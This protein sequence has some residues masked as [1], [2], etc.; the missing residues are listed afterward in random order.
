M[1]LREIRPDGPA[2]RIAISQA[3]ACLLSGDDLELAVEVGP[4]ASL[5][6]LEL[7]GMVAHAT[8]KGSKSR[9]AFRA[10]LARN[11][12][13]RW[14]SQPFVFA[15]DCDVER[16]TDLNLDGGAVALLDETLVFGRHGEQ[17]GCFT[18]HTRA[19]VDGRPLLDERMESGF[20]LRS[21]AGIGTANRVY[22]SLAL[23]GMSDPEPSPGSM[24]LAG[25]GSVAR[26]LAVEGAECRGRS[27]KLRDRWMRLVFK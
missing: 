5:D 16:R 26:F 1:R 3:E 7:G 20:T 23:L 10:D 18:S 17:P 13:L 8:R 6:L 24:E 22:G 19:M 14:Q 9:I 11:A 12:R 21:M 27:L 2:A 15:A 4:G 25:P